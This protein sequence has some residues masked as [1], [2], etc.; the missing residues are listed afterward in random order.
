MVKYSNIRNF[1]RK[2]L[3]DPFWGYLLKACIVIGV[4]FLFEL[5]LD[6]RADAIYKTIV[7]IILGL[8][9]AYMSVMAGM[10]KSFTDAKDKI[11]QQNQEANDKL[12]KIAKRDI[13]EKIYRKLVSTNAIIPDKNEKLSIT[14]RILGD[15]PEKNVYKNAEAE[16]DPGN[17][18]SIDIVRLF[19]YQNL[20]F[21]PKYLEYLFYRIEI[22]KKKAARIIVVN[23]EDISQA[24][25]SF[26]FLSFR[27]GYETYIISST[28]F[29]R[30]YNKMLNGDT[31]NVKIVK[32]NPFLLKTFADE[33][34]SYSGEYVDY[35]ANIANNGEI[36]P[37]NNGNEIWNLID[38]LKN[39]S[40]KMDSITEH[41]DISSVKSKLAYNN[42]TNFN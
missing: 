34:E 10:K 32:G 14:A 18:E 1:F 21:T 26:I 22:C 15:F 17:T 6:G 8:I 36:K 42:K 41:L 37:I 30:F 29:K 9:V 33:T 19:S 31:E 39:G 27:V 28:K 2:L 23:E 4:L 11:L 35:Q 13:E 24:T 38:T 12:L 20:L 3:E 40:A 7:Y 25:V 16:K 5:V